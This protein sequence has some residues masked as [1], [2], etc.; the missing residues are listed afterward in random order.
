[1]AERSIHTAT[2]TNP[3]W[4]LRAA[5]TT[6]AATLILGGLPGTQLPPPPPAPLPSRIRTVRIGAFASIVRPNTV[7]RRR[8]WTRLRSVLPGIGRTPSS[9]PDTPALPTV[10]RPRDGPS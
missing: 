8:W 3:T 10:G 1:M 9:R 2:A 5:A 7:A 4:R 6:T